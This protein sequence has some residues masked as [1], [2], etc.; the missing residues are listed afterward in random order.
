VTTQTQTDR[1]R[2]ERYDAATIEPRWQQRWEE[3]GLHRTDLHDESRPKFYLLTMY[4]YPSGDIHIGHW[5]IVTPTDA[6]ARFHRM[7]GEN[8][9]LP[10]GFDAFGLP[11]ENAAI[12]NKINPR[13]WTMSNIDN[14]RRQLRS[15]GATYRGGRSG[16]ARA[17]PSAS[18]SAARSRSRRNVRPVS[19]RSRRSSCWS[20]SR[21]RRSRRLACSSLI[22]TDPPPPAGGRRLVGAT[23]DFGGARESARA[24]SIAQGS[25]RQAQTP[26]VSTLDR[27][28]EATERGRG[29]RRS[30]VPAC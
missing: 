10:I 19:G 25:E 27:R 7:H 18:A 5:Y 21:S 6:I 29:W 16:A 3:L 17:P 4:P 26:G 22:S 24:R 30:L 8:V 11:A 14:M 20:G 23:G 28:G 9:F 15:M 12:K 1:P 2:I 13:D